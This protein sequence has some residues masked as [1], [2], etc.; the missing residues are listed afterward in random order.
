MKRHSPLILCA[1]VLAA[2]ATDARAPANHKL[3]DLDIS[4]ATPVN[5]DFSM[6][7]TVEPERRFEVSA[8]NGEVRNKASGI[9][10]VHKSGLSRSNALLRR[11]DFN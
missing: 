6:L 2:C 8:T 3:Y 11:P 1:L 4:F 7:T 10:H 9:L 5:G